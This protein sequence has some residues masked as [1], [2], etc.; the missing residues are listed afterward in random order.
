MSEHNLQN[1]NRQV[2]ALSLLAAWAA[3]ILFRFFQEHPIGAQ[4]IAHLIRM[5]K[6]PPLPSDLSKIVLMGKHLLLAFIL[7]VIGVMVGR[8]L[9]RAIGL[10]AA[11][12]DTRDKWEILQRLI[13]SLGLG[14]GALMYLTLLLGAVGGL[15][16]AAIWGV[17]ALLFLACIRDLP[18]LFGDLRVVI[19]RTASETP[20]Q[21]ARLTAV[22]LGIMLLLIGIMALAPSI[23]HDA[24]VYHLHVPRQYALAHRI[25]AIPYDLFSNTFLNMEMLYTAALLLDDFILANLMHYILGLGVLAFLYSFA[26]VNFGPAVAAIATLMFF[27]NKTFLDQMSLAYIDIGMTFYFILVMFC[28]WKWK[29][30]G[31]RRWFALVCVFAGIFAGMKY[32]SIYGLVTISA[33]IAF[34]SFG[35]KE[36]RMAAA[37]KNLGVYGLTVTLFV[38]PYLLKNYIISSNP[39]YPVGFNIFGGQWLTPEQVDRMLL[40]VDSHG[41]GRD[42]LHML[43][44]PWNITIYG[45]VGFENFDAKITPLWL[46]FFPALLITR[47]NPPLVKWAA[48]ACI[49]YF[50]SWAA[51]TH[52]TRYMLPMFPLLSLACAYACVS[53]YERAASH[54]EILG[55]N[56]KQAV[57]VV[58][59]VVWL[60]FSYFYPTRVPGEFGPAVW[61][62]QERD[63]FLRAKVPNYDVFNYINK[64][65]PAEARLV[66]FFDNRGFFCERQKIGDS[67]I[68]APMMIELVHEAGSAEAFHRKLLEEGFTHVMYNSHFHL[69]FP[70]HTISQ[71]DERRLKADLQ[72]FNEFLNIFCEPLYKSDLATVY[73]LRE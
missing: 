69:R 34:V 14:W 6:L 54:S 15:Y 11:D 40:Y 64:N 47:P 7:L 43:K 8:L 24:M 50:L 26:R 21:L 61:G 31:G 71:D 39:V 22:V 36:H 37:I 49:I 30:D 20:A 5:S 35:A 18:S 29:T 60:S 73:A 4:S 1:K 42:W 41:M 10:R 44:L 45:D 12:D 57:A 3:L 16:T 33:M 13:L 52:I 68:E 63:D 72:I 23:T 59:A 9:L 46:I 27:F 17:L 51:Y 58:C 32:T 55:R 62:R 48:Y 70:T 38:L 56:M 53:A 19:A 28:L 67:V 25:V 2:I 66:F 65:L